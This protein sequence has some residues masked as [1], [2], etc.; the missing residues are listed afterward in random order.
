MPELPKKIT[1]N[2]RYS[3]NLSYLTE[4]NGANSL[5]TFDVPPVGAYN[6]EDA[7]AAYHYLRH[8]GLADGSELKIIGY[9]IKILTQDI[10]RIVRFV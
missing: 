5:L 9:R 2:L 4:N 3:D 7:A 10:I 6:P 1:G 8:L